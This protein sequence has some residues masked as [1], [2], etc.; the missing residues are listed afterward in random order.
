MVEPLQNHRLQPRIVVIFIAGIL[1]S[2][3]VDDTSDP[4]DD[5]FEIVEDKVQHFT[6]YKGPSHTPK[7]GSTNV[8][9]R[10]QHSIE[11]KSP[12]HDNDPNF[13]DRVII[14]WCFASGTHVEV[15]QRL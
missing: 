7:D 13:D 1:Q 3:I 5:V 9:T 10:V 15:Q 8:G 12:T 14:E 2:R 6:Y 11:A 4:D